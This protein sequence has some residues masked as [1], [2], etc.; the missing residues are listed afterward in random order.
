MTQNNALQIRLD[1]TTLKFAND[2]IE[3]GLA[4]DDLTQQK[5]AALAAWKLASLNAENAQPDSPESLRT[6]QLA[7]SSLKKITIESDSVTNDND[8]LSA[9]GIITPQQAMQRLQSANREGVTLAPE[10]SLQLRSIIQNST[11]TYTQAQSQLWPPLTQSEVLWLDKQQEAREQRISRI[12]IAAAGPSGALA[13]FASAMHAPSFVVN[14]MLETGMGLSVGIVGARITPSMPKPSQSK[15]LASFTQPPLALKQPEMNIHAALWKQIAEGH[16]PKLHPVRDLSNA[17]GVDVHQVGGSTDFVFFPR[18]ALQHF[19]HGGVRNGIFE[20]AI[21]ATEDRVRYGSGQEIFLN[22]MEALRN[23]GVNIDKISG[24][25]PAKWK[26]TTNNDMFWKEI[27]AGKSPEIAACN[28]FTGKMAARLGF[29][30]V[31]IPENTMAIILNNERHQEI[32]VFFVRPEWGHDHTAWPQYANRW[33]TAMGRPGQAISDQ[34]LALD[35]S[36]HVLDL[37]P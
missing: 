6:Q 37:S 16:V 10:E 33:V 23:E 15:P 24:F 22:V 1:E 34:S 14:R 13:A 30:G 25:W 35:P 5:Q 8:R 2:N 4:S 28:T 36:N 7:I 27:E 21:R 31:E 19:A 20:Y 11:P 3:K 17:G 9:L 29:T 12:G 26:M 32:H 18:G